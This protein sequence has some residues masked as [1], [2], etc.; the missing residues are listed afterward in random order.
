MLIQLVDC[1]YWWSRQVKQTD[2]SVES[3]VS[4][5]SI[6]D[7]QNFIRD[8]CC[9]YLLDHPVQMGGPGRTVEV[10]ESKFMHQKYHCS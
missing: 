7:W 10:D 5:H 1:V 2:A 3:G 8:I 4:V 6:I 9:Q